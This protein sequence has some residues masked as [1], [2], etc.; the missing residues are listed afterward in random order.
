MGDHD[1]QAVMCGELEIEVIL[2]LMMIS[3]AINLATIANTIKT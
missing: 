1:Y 2:N 3:Q